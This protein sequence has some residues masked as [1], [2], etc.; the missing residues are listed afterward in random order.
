MTFGER[1]VD[2]F[3]NVTEDSYGDGDRGAENF[4]Y[5]VDEQLLVGFSGQAGRTSFIKFDLDELRDIVDTSSDVDNA[6][7][8][9][10]IGTNFITTEGML[11]VHILKKS[12][13]GGAKYGSPATNG[14]VTWNSAKHNQT[15]WDSPGADGSGD[16]T[17]PITSKNI[18]VDSQGYISLDVTEGVEHMIDTGNDY[19]FT[20]S[21]NFSGGL[22]FVS[23]ESNEQY[24][25]YLEVNATV[26]CSS[27]SSS[28][29][30][31]R[32]SSSSSSSS[33][34]SNSSSSSSSES[35]S[36]SYI[37]FF[38]FGENTIAQYTGVTEDTFLYSE[39]AD[40]NFGEATTLEILREM[41]PGL[42]NILIKF[43]LT[44][45]ESLISSSA[46]IEGATLYM[47]T[48]SLAQDGIEVAVHQINRDWNGGTGI[49]D[50][51][52][53]GEANY[54]FFM[55]TLDPHYVGRWSVAG[56][57]GTD[58]DVDHVR[59]EMSRNTISESNT[60]YGWDVKDS[61]KNQ[62]TNED[63]YGFILRYPVLDGDLTF[64]NG[65]FYSSEALDSDNRPYLVI[66]LGV[67]SSSSSSS[68]S[69]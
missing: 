22:E 8:N 27:S 61:V 11:N 15:L 6:T 50:P 67:T 52:L 31:S 41:T 29:S 12:W 20:F 37:G 9:L 48:T 17:G 62:F 4:N 47:K 55:Y 14:E 28:S 69:S 63:Y 25:P 59:E 35:S 2:T 38:T 3:N 1:D 44:A 64:G 21:Y 36:S 10:F 39:L 33:S 56:C 42:K 60:W 24:R 66:D 43:D 26:S 5:G 68:S 54:E 13:S 16:R 65:E 53:L 40:Y 57:L 45:L 58:L 49:G 32:S 7:L 34:T 51:A 23:S 19:G 46:Y 18:T 30:S